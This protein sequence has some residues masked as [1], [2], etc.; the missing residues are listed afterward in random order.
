MELIICGLAVIIITVII[1]L[2]FRQKYVKFS[3]D[4]ENQIDHFV[5][6]DFEKNNINKENLESKINSKLYKLGNIVNAKM[7]QSNQ[8]KKEVQEM[9]SDI[10]HQVKIPI[11]NIRMYSDTIINND[12]SKEKEQEFLGI[13]SNQVDKLEFLMDSLTKMSRLETNMIVLNKESAK[14]IECIESAK[15]Q[16]SH[17]AENKNIKI[18][19]KGDINC[20]VSYDK[21]WT[22]EAI[23]NILENAI[24]YTNENGK[25]TINLEKLESFLKIDIIDNG[26]GIDNENINNIFKRFF[27]EQKVH[28]IEGVGIGL[29]LSKNIIELQNGYIKVKSQVDV[30]KYIFCVFTTLKTDF[31]QS[32]FKCF[33][34]EIIFFKIETILKCLYYNIDL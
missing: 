8:A 23:C 3:N 11:S 27:R 34:I 16:V 7:E 4:I 18:D 12:L 15:E 20:I 6:G 17:F 14:F 31:Y 25:L 10:T 26:I 19:I 24:K 29:Y 28:N 13:I 1:Y 21:K 9:V 22:L 32:F 33:K 5:N 2:I 30:R